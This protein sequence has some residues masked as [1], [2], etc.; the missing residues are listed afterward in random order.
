[1]AK[2]IVDEEDILKGIECCAE[3]MCGEC[4]YQR[5]EH[6]D[7]KMRCIHMLMEDIATWVKE[8]KK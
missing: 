2:Y 8:I 1:M 4:P 3:Y 6:K 5:F 7:Y